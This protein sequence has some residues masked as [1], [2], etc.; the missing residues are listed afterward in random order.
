MT[1]ATYTNTGFNPHILQLPYSTSLSG[2]TSAYETPAVYIRGGK[3][4][5]SH[6]KN[7]K[8]KKYAK[9]SN[10]K[11]KKNLKTRKSFFW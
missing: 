3:R 11:R 5:K 4:S 7:M 1:V 8:S 6:K 2:N 9:K 10:K